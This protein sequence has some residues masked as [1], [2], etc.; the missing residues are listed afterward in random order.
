MTTD[1]RT[2]LVHPQPSSAVPP[3]YTFRTIPYEHRNCE[4]WPGA[5][6]PS[7]AD[8]LDWF[9]HFSAIEAEDRATEIAL[10]FD[11]LQRGIKVYL[12]SGSLKMALHEAQCTREVFYRQFNRCLLP[13]PLSGEGIVGWSG[14]ISQLRLKSYTRVNPG[15]GTAGQFQKW[16]RDNPAWRD[17]LHRM[18]QKG[19][20]GKR[21]AARKPD[22]RSVTRTFISAFSKPQGESK[23]PKI[24]VGTYPHDGRSNARRAIERYIKHFIAMNPSTS[25]VWFGEDVADRQH[26]GTGQQSFNFAA[27]PFDVMGC[28]AHTVDGIGFIILE[29]ESGPQ[30]VP[31]TRFQIVA[32]LCHN[33]RVVTGYSI[34][35]RPQIEAA[36]VEEAY[37]M[38]KTQWKPKAL[39][40]EGLRYAEGAGFPNEVVDG[41]TEINPAL[42]RLDNAAQHFAKGIRSR[43]RESLGCAIVWGG[44]GHWWRNAITERLFGTLE[45][46]G[47]QRLPSSMGT[48]TQDPHRASN[49]VIEAT[50]KGIE[51]HEL[52]ELIDVLLA[53]YNAKPHSSLGGVSPLDSLRASLTIRSSRWIPRILPPH[54][55]NSPRIGVQILR[56]RIA[57]SVK[58]RVPPYVEIGEERY[59]A[60]CLSSRYDLLGR[61]VYVHFPQDIRT[62]DCYLDSGQFIGQI[63]CLNR[64]WMLSAHTL[65][66]RQTINALIRSGEMWVPEGGDPVIVY[67]K[68]LEK[69]ATSQAT[70]RGKV[71]VSADASAVADGLLATGATTL[72][73]GDGGDT[74][75]LKQDTRRVFISARL[76]SSWE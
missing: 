52:I 36:H 10:R 68:H 20:G 35:I 9:P 60:D 40:I 6:M 51:W 7:V 8:L 4:E 12:S 19:N 11:R 66:T 23:Q 49:P 30:K 3:Y 37:L 22:V 57:G 44:V 14:L 18:I 17:M 42:L 5:S 28:D 27:A 48:G 1:T 69:K 61:H 25:A 2:D 32:T 59:T 26:L 41:I 64:G 63:E 70:A 34:C 73:R 16:L 50:G 39:S 46:Y 58:A 31:V 21:M 47:F 24:P 45:R 72:P 54:T 13:N 56:K 29:G 67:L 62:V 76:P 65:Q 38:G 74:S 55:A 53:N 43:L 33:K 15:S 71:Q 75:G